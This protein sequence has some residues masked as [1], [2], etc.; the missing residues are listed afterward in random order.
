M[1]NRDSHRQL[2]IKE[3]QV[4]EKALGE[5]ASGKFEKT[6]FLT[7][8]TMIVEHYEKLLTFTRRITK[9]SDLQAKNLLRR[10][11]EIKC[12]LDHAGQG[13]L[14][15]GSDLI[16]DREYSA[17]CVKIFGREIKH[18]TILNVLVT[19]DEDLNAL[20]AEVFYGILNS[21]DSEEQQRI[22]NRLPKV[23]LIRERDIRIDVKPIRE[24]IEE[25]HLLIMLILTDITEQRKA[26]RQVEFLSYHDK[27]TGLYNRAYVESWIESFRSEEHFPLSVMIMDLNGLK[28]ANDV[29]G[30][31]EGDKLLRGLGQVLLQSTRKSDIVAR[32][33]GDEF[34]ILLPNSD[35]RVCQ[36]VGERILKGCQ[37]YK[38][39]TV[40]LSVSL[41]TATQQNPITNVLDLFSIA[42]SRM[43]SSKL[44]ETKNVRR[45]LIL[46]V[47]KAL[48]TR[49]YEDVGH[50]DRVMELAQRF[51]QSI[52]LKPGSLEFDNLS[53]LARLHDI[54][55][56]AIPKEILGK[57]T[58]F[59]LNEW[60]VM[61]SHCEI[62]FRMAQSIDEP[63]VAEAILALRE[64]W[65]GSGYPR[66]LKANEIPFLS[67]L[68]AIV[69][70]YDVMTHNRP[71][72]Q[73]RTHEEAIQEL[74]QGKGT[75]FDSILVDQFA[76]L[77][78]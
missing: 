58:R 13:F 46:S 53:L 41:G 32:W 38:D 12:L 35:K 19:E 61:Q 69:D 30:H 23:L 57:S 47:E 16:I 49:F 7:D 8:Y 25:G 72:R 76:S 6:H 48:H 66:G 1:I 29:F 74:V 71:Y 56:I 27:L 50:I 4:L 9:I 62:G 10:E 77:M 3:L 5:I 59:T 39:L 17:E 42:E 37:E 36:K 11:T 22:I 67:R 20:I 24:G 43:Y 34:L 26:Q 18:H 28:L 75:Q 15:F 51:A 44:L 63:V 70:A 68:F 65:D 33:G 54:G 60:E 40:E 64:R 78:G 31:M 21:S 14:T 73:A 45:Q 52:G 2:F 55:K